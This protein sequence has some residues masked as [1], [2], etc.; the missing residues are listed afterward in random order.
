MTPPEQISMPK[1][2]ALASRFGRRTTPKIV[3]VDDNREFLEELQE[4]LSLGGYETVVVHDS[5]VALEEI[6]RCSP[7]LVLLD[8]KMSPKSGFEVAHELRH[9]WLMKEVPII[10]MT[11]FFT[12]QEHIWMTKL[13]GIKN[14]ILKPFNPLDLIAKIEFV[15]EGREELQNKVE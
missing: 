10:A 7:D 11:G 5:A 15:L 6:L 13:C 12:K 8:L 2:D 4:M 14:I 3:I 1:E 9:E